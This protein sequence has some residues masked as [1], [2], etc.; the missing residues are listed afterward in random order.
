MKTVY[1]LF[2]RLRKKTEGKNWLV[3]FLVLVV[4]FTGLRL[5]RL[6][7]DPSPDL[8]ISAALYTDEGFKAYSAINAVRNG[9]WRWTPR[10]GYNGWYSGSPVP[11]FLYVGWFK[12]FGVSFSALRSMNVLFGLFTLVALFFIVRR[13]YD[14]F[15]AF[16]AMTLFGTSNFLI[17][18]NRM[19]FFENLQVFFSLIVFYCFCEVF[20]RR[21]RIKEALTNK[22]I[23]VSKELRISIIAAAVGTVATAAALMTKQSVSIVFFALIPFFT[24]YFFYRHRT[25]SSL[26]IKKFYF[27]IIAFTLGYLFVAHFGWFE[28]SFRNI[29]DKKFFDVSLNYLFPIKQSSGTHLGVGGSQNF[30]P[31]YISF[32]K[33]LYLEFVFLQ[34]IVFFSGLFFAFYTYY[35]FLYRHDLHIMDARFRPGFF[36]D[37][38]FLQS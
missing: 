35:K 12:I 33:S 20:S 18:Y 30:D 13:F 28:M 3:Y 19:G 26:L 5:F 9:D 21:V 11:T 38:C 2:K 34:P 10:D 15:T 6:S 23:H 29:L 17:M 25:L 7:A 27:T 37:F 1:P 16:V 24:H 36:S 31:V 4:L 32:V 14:N 22:R 8:S